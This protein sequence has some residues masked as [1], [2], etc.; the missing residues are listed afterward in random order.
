MSLRTRTAWSAAA[1]LA[2]GGLLTGCASGAEPAASSAATPTAAATLSERDA[3]LAAP[4]PAFDPGAFAHADFV[5]AI[6][7][8]YLSDRTTAAAEAADQKYSEYFGGSY[9]PPAPGARNVVRLTAF[10]DPV[11]A[12]RLLEYGAVVDN[13]TGPNELVIGLHNVQAIQ[14]G[15]E[16]NGETFA[17]DVGGAAGTM[18]A[19]DRLT[20]WT[21][22]PNYA[23]LVRRYDF[24][25]VP[26]DGDAGFALVDSDSGAEEYIYSPSPEEGIFQ[27]TTYTCWPPNQLDQRLVTRLHQ[28]SSAVVVGSVSP[29]GEVAAP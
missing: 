18:A 14:G 15:V 24:E 17:G 7:I 26:A 12:V 8:Q 23:D 4:P 2:A 13:I 10:E 6:D 9:T 19:G 22:D 11:D 21:P 25:V 27:L 1:L 20:I 5:G 29:V 16:L 3:Y 28:V